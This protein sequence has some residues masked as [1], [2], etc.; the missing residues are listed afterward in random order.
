MK[1]IIWLWN[2]WDE[3]KNTRHNVWFLFVNNFQE[4]YNFESFKVDKKFDAAISIWNYKWEKV[5]LV[6]PLTFMNLSGRAVSKIINFYKIDKDDIITIS[7]DVSMI[8]WKIRKRDKWTAGWHNWLKS[9]IENI[10]ENFKRIKIWIWHDVKYELSSWVL[11]KFTQEELD[12][13]MEI[14]KNVENL[15]NE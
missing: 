9:I 2:P 7:D 4:K 11:W 5:I 12:S 10:W 1:V 3:Y 14:F 8:F 13:L 6:K 15:I